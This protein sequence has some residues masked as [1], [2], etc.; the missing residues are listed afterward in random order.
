MNRHRSGAVF[1]LTATT[2]SCAHPGTSAS[3][4]ILQSPGRG[5]AVYDGEVRIDPARGTLEARWRITFAGDST[6]TAQVRLNRGFTVAGHETTV[7]GSEQVITVRSPVDLAY[8][9][10]L[11]APGDSINRVSAAWTELGLDSFWQPVIDGFT[12]QIVGRVR[13]HLPA[14]Y[15]IAASAIVRRENGG[16]FTLEQRVPL[17]DFPF[18]AA[19]ALASEVLGGTRVYFTGARPALAAP[20]LRTSED[21]SSYLDSLYGSVERLPPRTMVLAPRT[22]PGYARKNYIVITNV[23]TTPTR[24]GRFVCHELAHF[25]SLRANSTGPDNWLNEGFAEFISAQYVRARIG[26]AAYDTIVTQWRTVGERQPAVWTPEST[27]R[28]NAMISYRKAPYLLT[29]LEARIGS[30]PMQRVLQRY[31]TEPIRTTP[32]LIAMIG[33]VTDSATAGWFRD[34][35]S[36]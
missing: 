26:P 34:L 27:R 12:H 15:Q 14:G 9:G 16:T 7:A 5:V 19:P 8:A 24:L 32:E 4:P 22:G 18:S 23:D 1:L 13:L 11:I 25:W 31:M 20:V 28:P 35:L 36:R 21:C 33:A 6:E 2:L 3:P 17:I 30:A 29:Q 10:T